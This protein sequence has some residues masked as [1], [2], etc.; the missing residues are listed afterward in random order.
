MLLR[1]SRRLITSTVIGLAALFVAHPVW[2]AP[3]TWSG[4][5]TTTSVWGGSNWL[6]GTLPISGTHS[7]F[8]TGSNR[9]TNTAT[10]NYNVDGI[11]FQSGAQSFTLQGN[12]SSR[13]L[14]HFGDIV[15]NSGILQT[16]GGTTLGTK[17]VLSYGTSTAT[18]AINT[19][20]GT[21]DMNAQIN[22]GAD[23]TLVKTGAGTL[24]LDN[25]PGT[26]H[27]FNGTFRVTQGTLNLQGSMPANFVV[28]S[29]ATVNIDPAAAGQQSVN[30][31]SM[32]VSGTLNMIGSMSV[33]NALTLGS[34][35]V[36]NF[37]L[38]TVPNDTQLLG[39]GDGSSFGGTLN[40]NLLGVYPGAD[41]F[42]PVVFTILQQQA[43]GATGNFNAVNATYN[44]SNLS[45]SQ[46]L[47][48]SRPQLWVSQA[49]ADGQYLTFD[50]LTGEMVVVPEPSTVVF[51]GIGAA[52]AGWH[53]LKQRRRRRLE[54]RPRFED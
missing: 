31:G 1:S 38:P 39:Y 33:N 11:T 17:L 53:M 47:D 48:A 40:A 46:G 13:T 49:T 44:G 24:V 42:N 45:F 23:V 52:M 10:A 28:S 37:T 2:A 6:S 21:I 18:R 5:S 54:S 7:L 20:S 35:S 12:S 22:G 41:L 16:I 34:T 8:F 19:G 9:L 29:T 36:T 15:N 51:A 32:D 27:G 50:Q 43:G 30:V 25:P 3:Y 14:N 26:G 4:A